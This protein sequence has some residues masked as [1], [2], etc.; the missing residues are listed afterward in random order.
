MGGSVRIERDAGDDRIGWLVFDHPERRNAISVD[1]WREIPAAAR[2]LERDPE[3]RVV[4]MRGAGE[5][6]FVA[7]AD[8]SEFGEKRSG[9][10][11]RSYDVESARAFGALANLS[12]PLLAMIHGYCVGGGVAIALTAD[13]RYAASD[14]RFAIPAARLGLGYH[15]SGVE[16]LKELVGPSRAKEIFFTARRFDA[17]EALAMGLVNGVLPVGALEQSVRET[18]LRIAENAPLTIG[19]VKRIVHELAR[20]PAARD[21]DAVNDS[22]RA[23]FESEDYREGVRAFLEKRPP[24]FRGR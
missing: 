23:C 10:A 11:A 16:A 9:D 19:S 8:I 13:M 14:A 21:L 2:Q 7:G 3:V 18:A 20:E 12:K 5:V 1:M 24:R 15:A 22:I 6:A 17:S 4:V